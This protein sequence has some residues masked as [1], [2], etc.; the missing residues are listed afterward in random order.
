MSVCA[1]AQEAPPIALFAIRNP[2][3][4]GWTGFDAIRIL[5]NLDQAFVVVAVVVVVLNLICWECIHD[6]EVFIPSY[7]HEYL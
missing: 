5:L 7:V 6:L 1:V 2:S 3:V 4:S